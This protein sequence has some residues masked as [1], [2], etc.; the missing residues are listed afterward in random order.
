MNVKSICNVECPLECDSV[1]YN[2][3]MSHA[4]Y[5][6]RVY[7]SLLANNTKIIERYSSSSNARNNLSNVTYEFLKE[8]MLELSVFYGELGYEKY[9]E[10]PKMGPVDIVS[11]IGGT[12][13]LFLG[14]SFLSFVELI[15]IIIRICCYKCR[16]RRKDRIEPLPP[17]KEEIYSVKF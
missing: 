2:S 15:D 4:D 17:I 9:E 1:K 16:M 6:S 12:L 5:P 3:I 8:H 11:S 10:S 7:A 14:M 13:G